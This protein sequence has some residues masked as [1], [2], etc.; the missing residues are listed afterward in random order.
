MPD[1]GT[2]AAQTAVTCIF[3]QLTTSVSICVCRCYTYQA[4][5]GE[6]RDRACNVVLQ[7]VSAVEKRQFCVSAEEFI[8]GG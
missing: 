5:T 1:Q 4:V 3:G 6:R 8:D 2:D 7:S